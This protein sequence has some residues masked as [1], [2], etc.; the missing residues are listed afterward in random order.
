M[1]GFKKF[2]AIM[3]TAAIAVAAVSGCGGKKS[4]DA[5]WSVDSEGNFIPGDR[6]DIN[7]WVT[8]GSDYVPPATA[9][10]NVVE[11]WLVDKTHVKVANAFG[12]GGGQWEAMLGRLVAGDNFPELVA[13]G[14]GQ[15]PAHFAKIAEADMIWDLSPELLQKYAPDIWEKVPENMWERIKV[16][17]K[18][19]GI[20]YNFPVDREINPSLSNE[21]IETFGAAIPSNVGTY[22]WIRDDILKMI[23]PDAMS[24]DEIK[25][26]IDEKGRPVGDEVYDVPIE[27]TEDFVK[28]MRDIKNLNLKVG[29]KDVYAFGYAGAD[30]WVPFA[31]LGAQ[32]S[33]YV[34]HH[35]IS[36]WNT[37]TNEMELPL[38]GD[39]IKETA[40]LQ[41]QLLR[42]NVI[43][44]DSLMHTDSQC[45]EKVMNGQYAIAVLSALDHPP[46]INQALESAGKEFRYR[47]L[48]TKVA[49]KPGYE[50]T[51]QPVNWGS[52]VGILKT[53]SEE[54]LPQILNWMNVQ[55][56]DEW[57]EI[58]YW[59]P[60]TAGLY[61]DNAD[62][63]RTFGDEELNKKFV[64]G[65]STSIE[66][67]DCYGLQYNCGPFFM[68]YMQQS[69]WNPAFYNNIKSWAVL[70]E[71]GCKLQP[72]SKL[73]ATP[74]KAPPMDIWSAEYAGVELVQE[75]WSSRSKWE[76]PFKL[77]L[78]ATSDAE[79][80]EKWNSAVENMK[81]VVDTG[82]MMSEVTE[83]AKG[84]I[85]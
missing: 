81:K 85:K 52:T 10:N 79:F 14:G 64:T 78:T 49:S 77:V 55:F 70:P 18:I 42:E 31:Q 36:S 23:Y 26:L 82:K 67:A 73:A 54:Q 68:Q 4:T 17:G 28:L 63:T 65:E 33:G 57:E 39:V 56:T 59:G 74:K 32:M 9:N 40:L 60:E 30:C 27:T 12:N 48:Y 75:F 69:E 16:D 83:I 38:L 2:A 51:K 44:Q 25:A 20:P 24:Y 35:Y 6:M 71:S 50:V 37:E 66:D 53:I 80:E 76:D 62:G 11:N 46:F 22:L 15:G 21:M 29:N 72:D 47:P 5:G 19:Y 58:R 61:T 1:K 8:Q 41:N 13:C 84:L 34:G 7:V 43:D 3:L 45:K